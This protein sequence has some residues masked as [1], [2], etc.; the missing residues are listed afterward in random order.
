[1]QIKK[2]IIGVL[3]ALGIR[4][5]GSTVARKLAQHFYHIDAIKQ[6]SYDDLIQVPEIG[7][8]IA[9]SVL[10]WLADPEN[11]VILSRLQAAG[12][13][14]SQEKSAAT[15]P[16]SVLLAGQTFVI[17]GVFQDHSREELQDLIS[18]NGGKMVSSIS[19]KLSYLVAG[20][21][22]G[23]AKLEKATELGIKIISESELLTLL[24]R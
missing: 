10:A 12:L 21:K 13:Q 23:P 6:A 19:K 7:D 18:A 15:L 16:Q 3:F 17:S 4:F 20:D 11:Q 14:F 24:G 1:M 9:L 5:V 8:R 22:M 2:L